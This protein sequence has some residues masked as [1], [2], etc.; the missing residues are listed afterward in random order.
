MEVSDAMMFQA[1]FIY[2]LHH[3]VKLLQR[4]REYV[5]ILPRVKTQVAIREGVGSVEVAGVHLQAPR[6]ASITTATPLGATL[7]QVV[8]PSVLFRHRLQRP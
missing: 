6:A 5:T 8:N 2:H 3:S 1:L 4:G 7:R